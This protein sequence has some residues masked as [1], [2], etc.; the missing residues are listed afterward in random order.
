MRHYESLYCRVSSITNIQAYAFISC[1]AL[2]N[3]FLQS[4][5]PSLLGP[6]AFSFEAS[7][8]SIHVPNGS[9]AAYKAATGWSDYASEIVSP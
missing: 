6:S 3:V 5:S 9:L 7:G 1:I 8:F 2:E 4:M